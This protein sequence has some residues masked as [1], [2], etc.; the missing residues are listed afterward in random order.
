MLDGKKSVVEKIVYGVFD[1][2]VEK[3]CEELLEV[4]ELVL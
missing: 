1:L 3:I 2:V 4:F